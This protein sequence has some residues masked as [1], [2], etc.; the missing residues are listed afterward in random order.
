M[1][2]GMRKLLCFGLCI[3]VFAVFVGCDKGLT[4]GQ[5]SSA[6]GT[7]V[8]ERVR[9]EAGNADS[10]VKTKG[11]CSSDS[12]N[13]KLI[14]SLTL[15]RDV[16]EDSDYGEPP[17]FAIWL[18]DAAGENIRT[19]WVSYRTGTGDWA[20]KV[21]CPVSLPYW[22]S[23]YN[24]ETE[25]VGPPSFR[26]PVVDAITG[27]TPK[28]DFTVRAEV[29]AGSRWRYFIEVNVSGDF[30]IQFPAYSSKGIPD[31]QGNGQPSLIYQGQIEAVDGASDT[32]ELVGRTDQWQPVDHIIA[33]LEDITSA[34]NI[35]SRIEVSCRGPR[36]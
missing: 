35:F 12:A 18:E 11:S 10:A 36:R 16:Y 2:G 14:F 29:P 26:E 27:A 4:T 31:P 8:L 30:N 34:K 7:D 15:N 23:R 6:N 13:A 24:K 5:V 25:T 3:A 9:P 32:P 22:V 19:V 1:K 20:G 28:Q 17:Q 33:E 21:E